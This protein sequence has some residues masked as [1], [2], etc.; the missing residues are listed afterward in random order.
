MKHPRQALR[1]A[2]VGTGALGSALLQRL[3]AAG[4]RSVLLMDPDTVELRNLP[5]SPY[6]Q[7]ALGARHTDAAL[8][9]KASLLA[10][11]AWATHRLPWR[12]LP[13]DVAS[14]GWQRLRTCDLLCCCTDTAL[15]R[16]ELAFIAHT[17]Q[18]PVLDGAVLGMGVA[19][20]RVTQFSARAD[21]ACY[22]CGLG[23]ERR[24]AVLGLAASAALGCRVLE[25]ASSMT[26]TRASLD[27]V[28]DRMAA[29]IRE[30]AQGY[31]WSTASC[32][33]RLHAGVPQRPHET[34]QLT[35]S[36]TCPWHDSAPS[37]LHSLAWQIPIRDSL[38]QMF[39]EREVVLDWPVCTQAACDTCGQRCA[40]FQ[41]VATVR[42]SLRCSQC[43][44]ASLQPLATTSHI[45]A[46]DTVAA[47]TPRQLGQPARHLYRLRICRYS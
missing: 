32:A 44:I 6:L 19:E 29:V 3:A 30:F 47:L 24:A 14:V 22:L 31:T 41:R 16:A 43:G 1:L 34:V 10:A 9:N 38:L 4:M 26:G 36:K 12:A 5:L 25:E 13:C 40:P 17:L 46:A 8:P 21:A 11:H 35:R 23:E 28:A 27:L 39:P 18:K 2:V 45:R 7:Q 20:G 37:D 42:K 33:M 15:S